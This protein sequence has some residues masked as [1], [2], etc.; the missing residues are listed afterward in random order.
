MDISSAQELIV[1]ELT[2][3][4]RALLYIIFGV[5]FVG[6][7]T[8]LSHVLAPYR[9]TPEKLMPYECGEEVM[10]IP[11]VQMNLRFYIVGLIFLI[12]EVE[13]L[14]LFPWATVFAEPALLRA[15]PAWG[16]LALVEMV[17][18]VGLLAVGLAYVWRRGDLSWVRPTPQV[19]ATGAPVP[20]AL[21]E[22]F[23]RQH[24]K[25]SPSPQS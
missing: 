18:F 15:I 1:P 21:Y 5:L 7:L 11:G 13:V 4:G 12:F 9:P 14:F 3:A 20:A 19:P 24:L 2:E 10:G 23:N 25:P 17:V 6:L 8:F 16:I 22:A